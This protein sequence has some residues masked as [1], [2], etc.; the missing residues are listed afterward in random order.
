MIKEIASLEDQ[1]H[2]LERAVGRGEFSESNIKVKTKSK[3]PQCT[4]ITYLIISDHSYN[5]H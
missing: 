2:M 4:L 1:I 5:T 3:G